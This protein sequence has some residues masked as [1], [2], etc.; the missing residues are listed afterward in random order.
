[1]MKK[2]RKIWADKTMFLGRT[3]FRGASIGYD[4]NDRTRCQVFDSIGRKYDFGSFLTYGTLREAM[5]GKIPK[6]V[7]AIFKGIYE[8]YE[9]ATDEEIQQASADDECLNEPTKLKLKLVKYEKIENFFTQPD[10]FCIDPTDKGEEFYL[11]RIGELTERQSKLGIT[12]KQIYDVTEQLFRERARI[13]KLIL[14]LEVHGGRIFGRYNKGSWPSTF[15]RP[16]VEHLCMVSKRPNPKIRGYNEELSY[17]L[18]IDRDTGINTV[19]RDGNG[20]TIDQDNWKMF[21][22]ERLNTYKDYWSNFCT[23]KNTY[24]ERPDTAADA[25]REIA[26]IV[27]TA[28]R[29]KKDKKWQIKMD[30]RIIENDIEAGFGDTRRLGLEGYQS[31]FLICCRIY[32][33]EGQW[34][35]FDDNLC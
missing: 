3:M 12:A 15:V 33:D 28:K 9:Q 18:F 21:L 26:A 13:Q 30:P 6:E 23:S 27:M 35:S 20:L 31:S 7:H 19:G 17:E 22:D 2:P 11:Q 29:F 34:G 25:A 32:M 8:W 16:L 14:H 1:M 4:F 5:R 10:K 24:D